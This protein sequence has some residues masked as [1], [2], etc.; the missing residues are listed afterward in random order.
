MLAGQRWPSEDVSTS[1]LGE[2]DEAGPV[3]LGGVPLWV[4]V[5]FLPERS[6]NSQ[7]GWSTESP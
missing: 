6:P 4:L 1:M 2:G 3:V 5:T 7:D